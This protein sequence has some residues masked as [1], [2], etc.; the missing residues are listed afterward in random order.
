MNCI[1]CHGEVIQVKEVK[2]ELTFESNIVYFPITIP[3]CQT[4]GERYYDR[5]A[6]QSLENAEQNLMNGK[7]VL[8][9][10]G[11]VLMYQEA[12]SFA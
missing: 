4:C 5:R 7:M 11:K 3:V 8:K 12:N 9:E 10:I 1:I 2:E 6:M